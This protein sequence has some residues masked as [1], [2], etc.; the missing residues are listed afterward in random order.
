MPTGTPSELAEIIDAFEVA[1]Q[2]IEAKAVKAAQSMM[3]AG[4]EDVALAYQRSRYHSD[5]G[6]KKRVKAYGKKWREEKVRKGYDKRKGHATGGIQKV[7]DT[8]SAAKKT[9]KG[10]VIDFDKVAQRTTTTYKGRKGKKV[11]KRVGSYLKPHARDKAPSVGAFSKKYRKD[12]SVTV[13]KAIEK[14]LRNVTKSAGKG[15]YIEF[16]LVIDSY[17]LGAA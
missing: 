7:F 2:R 4:R 3:Q 8:K 17:G 5:S 10:F 1:M 6:S 9:S 15:K 16:K 11:K 13:N 12:L 14:D